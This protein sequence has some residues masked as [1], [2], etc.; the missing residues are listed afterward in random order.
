MKGRSLFMTWGGLKEIERKPRFYW[1]LQG[2][3]I[4]EIKWF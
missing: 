1:F 2:F 4:W 3:K